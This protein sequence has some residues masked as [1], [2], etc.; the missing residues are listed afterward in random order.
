MTDATL[1]AILD[2]FTEAKILIFGDLWLEH[3]LRGSAREGADGRLKIRV[4]ERTARA[5]GAG[6]VACAAA[7]MGARTWVA[8][9][10]GQDAGAGE[11]LRALGAV[12]ADT[13]AVV[14]SPGHHTGERLVLGLEEVSAPWSA[15]EVEVHGAPPLEGAAAQEMLGHIEAI[16]GQIGAVTILTDESPAETKV[17]QRLAR[18][19]NNNGI[20]LI[21]GVTSTTAGGCG[22]QPLSTLPR[23][24]LAVVGPRCDEPASGDEAGRAATAE[25]GH[26]A[27]ILI[28]RDGGAR[29]HREGVSESELIAEPHC[30]GCGAWE[31]FMAGVALG[32]AV[33]ADPLAAGRIGAA[34]AIVGGRCGGLAAVD[35][36]RAEIAPE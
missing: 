10:V 32:M 30:M 26:K 16:I 36:I 20:P 15:V 2:R 9:A 29:L 24:D 27:L 12:A 22:E 34:A 17:L 5:G 4:S 23:C 3:S 13:F 25:M 11:A 33:G 14:S 8:A 28:A 1:G 21:G 31:N 6:G 7:A 35:D 19:A 18:L